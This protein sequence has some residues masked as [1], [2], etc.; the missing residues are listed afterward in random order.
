[1]TLKEL[2]PQGH[3]TNPPARYTE[4]TLVKDARGARHRPPVDV[5]VDHRHDPR[6]RLRL[7]EGHGARADVPR[8]LRRHSCSSST[9]AASSTTTSRRGWRTTSTASPTGDEKRIDW[10]QPLLLRRRR[11]RGRRRA[12]GAR[13]RPRRD[14]RARDQLD[15]DRQRHRAPRRP[16]RPVSRAR[17]RARERSRRH[18]AR[19]ADRREGGGAARAAVAGPRARRRPR[20]RARQS[21]RDGRYGPVRQRGAA[22]GLDGEAARRRRCSS[23]WRSTRSRSRTRCSCSQLPRVIG[24]GDDG[25]EIVAP[26]AATARTSSRARRR[27]RSRR[28][29][30]LFTV[31]SRRRSRCSRSRRSGA[32]AA[33]AKPPLKELG[34][35][36]V[37]GKPIVVKEGRF[38]PYVTDG[39]TNA[40]LRTRRRPGADRRSTGRSSCSPNGAPRARR[41]RSGR[42]RRQALTQNRRRIHHVRRP[43]LRLVAYVGECVSRSAGGITVQ[44]SRSSLVTA[45]GVHPGKTG[46]SAHRVKADCA[47]A[48]PKGLTHLLT[49]NQLTRTVRI[50]SDQGA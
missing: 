31:T 33:Q 8:V 36:P 2:E 29:E 24:V 21:S 46:Q 5:R 15:P 32:A 50:R 12:E 42:R 45:D 37:S 20:D 41:R 6:P 11:R 47:H 38:G 19:R 28:E 9:S 23:R 22:G 1:M 49:Q 30:Q 40:S 26:T 48:G 39:E 18:R 43:D 25:E 7:Q 13:H 27:A 10:L 16:L 44:P 17:R 4:A 3:E 34:A 35:D 14:R